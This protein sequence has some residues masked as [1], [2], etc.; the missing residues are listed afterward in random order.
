[1][2][3][4]YKAAVIGCGRMGAEEWNYSKETQPETHAAAYKNNLKTDLVALVDIDSKKLKQAGKYFSGVAL[5]D[6]VKDMFEKIKPDIVSI[7]TN[8][9]SHAVLVKMAAKYKTSAI[10]CEKPIAQSIKQAE[11]MI[12]ICKQNKS[13]LFINHQR[14]FDPLLGR[15]QLEIKKGIIGKIVQANCYYYNGL[16]NSA[17]HVVDLLRFFLGDIDWVRGIINKETFWKENDKNVDA[18]IG[19]KNGTVVAMQTLPKNYGFSEFYFYGTKGRFA[20]K[21]LGYEIECRKLAENKY[22]KGFY[23][24]SEN[25]KKE[26]SARSLMSSVVNHIVSCLGDK[27]EPKS[28]GEDGLAA[29]KALFAMKESAEKQNKIINF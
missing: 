9:D 2:K 22:C 3:K 18:L 27:A 5:F 25:I 12:R 8:P 24:L 15:W 28:T 20:I 17:T 7:A 21:N 13:L 1:M 19:F 29:L 23:Q 10:L 26:G 4:I 6:S 16:F 14:R 11:E